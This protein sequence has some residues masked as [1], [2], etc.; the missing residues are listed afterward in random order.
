MICQAEA[1]RLLEVQ[2]QPALH[3]EFQSYAVR[4]CWGWEGCNASEF[5]V[6]SLFT[7]SFPC[8]EFHKG[9]NLFSE[10]VEVLNNNCVHC[11]HSQVFHEGKLFLGSTEDQVGFKTSF[12]VS[13]KACL[14][15]SS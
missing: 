3:C 8:N 5:L 14:L 12:S 15:R 4:F 2:G 7:C 9:R 13:L 10:P 11:E 6:D 1:R